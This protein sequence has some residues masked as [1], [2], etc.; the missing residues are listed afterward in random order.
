IINN[1]E[2]KGRLK[3]QADKNYYESDVYKRYKIKEQQYNENE[4]LKSPEK[5]WRTKGP[6]PPKKHIVA[7]DI[8]DCEFDGIINNICFENKKVY[9]FEL[10]LQLLLNF[11]CY[12]NFTAGDSHLFIDEGQNISVNEYLLLNNINPNVVFN[13]FGDVNQLILKGR[14]INSWDK[15]LSVLGNINI[16]FLKENYR[17]TIEINEYCNELFSFDNASLGLDG[18]AVSNV[19]LSELTHIIKQMDP[20]SQRIAIIS[21]RENNFV[22]K[23]LLNDIS[24]LSHSKIEDGFISVLTVAETKGLEFDIVYVLPD[25]MSDNEKYLSYTR[26]LSQLVLLSNE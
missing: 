20:S 18:V 16:Y 6:T 12:G 14:G 5:R 25:G 19:K 7:A 2:Y 24:Y 10:Y 22:L 4:M 17:N 9:K 26:A 21:T 8:Y 1:T 15:Q 23:N 3:K 13:I 11:M